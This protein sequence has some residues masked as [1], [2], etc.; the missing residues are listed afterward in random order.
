MV[1]AQRGTSASGFARVSRKGKKG[2]GVERDDFSDCAKFS[3]L[4]REKVI[5]C[6]AILCCVINF[7]ISRIY[8]Y[9][10]LDI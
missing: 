2:V 1:L 10:N 5:R 9:S 6:P 7:F 8:S 4:G 3:N